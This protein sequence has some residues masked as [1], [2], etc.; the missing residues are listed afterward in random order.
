METTQQIFVD[1][2]SVDSVKDDQKLEAFF[3]EFADK[4]YRVADK[5]FAALCKKYDKA[6]KLTV[7]VKFEEAK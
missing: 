2:I 4:I 1:G 5:K 3:E 7:V 6:A